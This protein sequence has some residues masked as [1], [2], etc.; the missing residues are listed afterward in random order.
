MLRPPLTVEAF[1]LLLTTK[2]DGERPEVVVAENFAKMLSGSNQP[3][4]TR[5]RPARIAP[6]SHFVRALLSSALRAFDQVS[7]CPKHLYS[8]GGNCNR[9]TVKLLYGEHLG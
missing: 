8:Q 1:G 2:G 6:S 4:A 7:P 5:A 9:C 3:E